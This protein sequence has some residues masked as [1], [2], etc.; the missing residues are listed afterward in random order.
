MALDYLLISA[1]A[2]DVEDWSCLDLVHA[3]DLNAAAVLPDL[4]E[5]DEDEDENSV[6]EGWDR[7]HEILAM[8]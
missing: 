3:E 6:Q 7:I 5:E 4:E 2:V 8:P 1:T